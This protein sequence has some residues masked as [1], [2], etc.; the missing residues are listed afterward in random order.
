MPSGNYTSDDSEISFKQ[1]RKPPPVVSSTPKDFA[2][3]RTIKA[4]TLQPLLDLSEEEFNNKYVLIDCR[5]PYEYAGGHIKYAINFHDYSTVHELFFPANTEK[6][7][8]INKKI[9]IFYCEFSQVRGPKMAAAL[10]QVDRK[11][12]EERYPFLDY[13]EMF[14][15]ERGYN[16]FYKTFKKKGYCV[17]DYYTPMNAK[18]FTHHLKQFTFHRAR[19][20]ASLKPQ[21][22]ATRVAD[23]QFKRKIK[24]DM[25]LYSPQTSTPSKKASVAPSLLAPKTSTPSKKAAAPS[26]LDQELQKWRENKRL[27]S[28]ASTSEWDSTI[29]GS[30]EIENLSPIG[31]SVHEEVNSNDE[32][33]ETL[34]AS[35]PSSYISPPVLHNSYCKPVQL[36]LVANDSCSFF[37][38]P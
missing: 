11:R 1:P 4:E 23:R 38:V 36:S 29:D 20:Q 33:I 18:R 9:P 25:A 12:N 2:A 10:R 26:L 37:L 6:Y 13:D 3:C 7:E 19:S 28:L 30:F 16:N 8:E 27:T 31:K 24:S 5:Y 32:A 34:E 17:P 21:T 22:Q 35:T 14:I 15:L